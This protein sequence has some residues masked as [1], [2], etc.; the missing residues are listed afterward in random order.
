MIIWWLINKE[1][2]V[3]KKIEKNHENFEDVFANV[4]IMYDAASLQS[5]T[6][7]IAL[8]TT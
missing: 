4:D 7:F 8:S 6:N 5:D 1:T 3:N 2:D